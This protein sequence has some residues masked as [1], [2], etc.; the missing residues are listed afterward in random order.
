MGAPGIARAPL[1]CERNMKSL[2]RVTALILCLISLSSGAE[3][4]SALSFGVE[5]PWIGPEYWSNP[6]QDWRIANGRIE[7]V[8]SGANRN[9][10]L[11]T[12]QLDESSGPFSLRV[13]L[14]HMEWGAARLSPGWA[15][16]RVGIRGPLEGYRSAAIRGEGINAGI[17]TTGRLFVGG[18]D[19][20]TAL[21]AS[22]SGVALDDVELRLAG[23]PYGGGYRLTISAHSPRTGEELASTYRVIDA[24]LDGNVAIVNDWTPEGRVS[25]QNSYRLPGNQ[26][27]G[28]VRFWFR[29]WKVSGQKVEAKPEQAWGPILWAQHTLSKGVMT[30]T[31]Q[32]API[33]PWDTAVAR[34]EIRKPGSADW[35]E[36]DREYIHTLARTATF[37]IADWE[38][39]RDVPYRV[40]YALVQTD[41]ETRDHYWTGTVRKDPVEKETIVVAGF[42]CAMD[43]NFPH[44]EVFTN[45][46]KIDPDIMLF[47]GDQIYEQV[48]GY[49]VDR[50]PKSIEMATLDYLRKWFLHG[51]A[52]G[53]L[54]RDRPTVTIPDDHDVYQGNIWGGEGAKTDFASHEE[55]GYA[56]PAEWVKMVHRT[57]TSNLPDPYD[58]RP[59]AQGIPVYYTDVLY[60]RISFGVI[61]DRKFKT[62][63]RGTVPESGGRPDHITDPDFDRAAFDPPGAKLLGDRQIEFIEDWTADWTGADM[64]VSVT[65]TI[66]AAFSTNHGAKLER[67]VADL[68][69][70]GWPK[71]G[72]DRALR[73]LRKGFAFLLGGDQHLPNVLHLG[74]D[75]FGDAGWSFCVPAISV[76]YQRSFEPL[77]PGKNR[78]PAQPDYMGDHL[79]S[80][81]SRMTVAAVANPQRQLR[82]H[83]TLQAQDKSSG[84]GVVRLNK[85][86]GE[87]TMECWGILSDADH[88]ES[89]YEDWPVTV[90]MEENYG[91]EAVAWL[92]EVEV[93]GMRNPVIQVID[94]ES[95]EH[96]YTLRIRGAKWTPKVFTETGNYTVRVGEPGKDFREFR[97][98]KAGPAGAAPALTVQF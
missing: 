55:G 48:A 54:M 50:D 32:M 16:F 67:L 79:D 56:M 34:L 57:Q 21:A 70:N 51:W 85:K 90:R 63:P 42:S 94:E 30:L 24:A 84:F 29:D 88:P 38:D 40:A 82:E 97:G 36:A 59:I 13:R 33:G 43:Y 95:G 14:G 81:D 87:I 91:R 96:V 9:V 53:D 17:T 37:R 69:S 92:P 4:E 7:C 10:N 11:L 71:S 73:E 45:V 75:D 74:V 49:G 1:F 52:F 12:Y 61:E 47:T 8:R 89:Q 5:R 18:E 66:F 2:S 27:G 20:I 80:F 77:T 19:A 86:T 76:G 15:G 83:P 6:L 3:F 65:Q 64:K 68:D 22:G 28:N 26:R 25:P 62:G 93:S 39:E 58:P 60:G 41:G 98:Q 46:E 23:R 72:R 35:E 44:P 31:A 78:K